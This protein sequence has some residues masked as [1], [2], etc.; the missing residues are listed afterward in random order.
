VVRAYPAVRRVHDQA[1][2]PTVLQA[3]NGVRE[4]YNIVYDIVYDIVYNI[5]YDIYT[6]CIYDIVYD[7]VYDLTQFHSAAATAKR[8]RFKVSAPLCLDSRTPSLRISSASL[9]E[10]VLGNALP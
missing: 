1:L 5:I 3:A 4:T 7:V 6:M 2:P 9:T 10:I 8:R